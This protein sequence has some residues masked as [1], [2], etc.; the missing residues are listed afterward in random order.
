M[1]LIACLVAATTARGGEMNLVR[2]PVTAVIVLFFPVPLSA[3][4]SHDSL[5]KG[6]CAAQLYNVDEH[7]SEVSPA[8]P[9]THM[10]SFAVYQ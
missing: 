10:L 9:L 4:K 8:S 7:L 3:I 1:V 2:L 6:L 5:P